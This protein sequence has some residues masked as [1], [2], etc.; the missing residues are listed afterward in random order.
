MTFDV[1]RRLIS[2]AIQGRLDVQVQIVCYF[3]TGHVHILGVCVFITPA[4]S[5]AWD[6]ID[7]EEAITRLLG[8]DRFCT[9]F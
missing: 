8:M 9:P 6:I 1:G 7:F 4:I 2:L 5:N 3:P